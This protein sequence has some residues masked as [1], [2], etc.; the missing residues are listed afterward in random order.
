MQNTLEILT[1][2]TKWFSLATH[3]SLVR[4]YQ[5]QMHAFQEFL[6]RF[7][8]EWMNPKAVVFSKEIS[9]YL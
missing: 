8:V 6:C 3:D 1:I 9:S 5:Q 2:G 4:S 7:I